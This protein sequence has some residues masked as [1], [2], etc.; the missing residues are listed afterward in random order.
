[1]YTFPLLV[2]QEKRPLFSYN[3]VRCI[4]TINIMNASK[5]NIAGNAQCSFGCG[6][7]VGIAGKTI[8]HNCMWHV[9]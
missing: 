7:L 8:F 6:M 1:M 5:H 4:S 3:N 9:E 2:L